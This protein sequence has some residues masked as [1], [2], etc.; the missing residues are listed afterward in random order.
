[1]YSSTNLNP[2]IS[3]FVC[4]GIGGRYYFTLREHDETLGK[5]MY[6]AIY[7]FK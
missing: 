6:R 7:V 1:M 5:I 3:F 2:F 4:R